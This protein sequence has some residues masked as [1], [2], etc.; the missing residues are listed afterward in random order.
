MK[1]YVVN[2][3]MMYSKDIA[4]RAENKKDAKKK[5]LARLKKKLPESYFRFSAEEIK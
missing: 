4:V 5:A 3:M 1:D 2:I